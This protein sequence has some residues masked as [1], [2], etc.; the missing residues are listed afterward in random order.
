MERKRAVRGQKAP[1]MADVAR[2][3]KVSTAAVSYVVSGDLD[4]LKSVGEGA[5]ARILKAIDDLNY[6]QNHA[7]RQLRRRQAERICLLLPRLG[8]PFSDR[9]AQDVRTAAESRNFSTIIAAGHTEAQIERVMLE[10]E[11]GLADGMIADLQHLNDAQVDAMTQRLVAAGKPA[12]VFHPT[13]QPHAFSVV[14]QHIGEAIDLALEHLYAAGHRRIA[15]ML[16]DAAAEQSRFQAYRAFLQRKGLAADPDLIVRGAS[17][18]AGADAAATDLLARKDRPT[19][20]LAE[21]D[22][23]AVTALNTVQAAGLRVPD[24]MAIVGCGDVDEG[25]FS[26]P[27]LTTVGPTSTSFAALADHLIAMILDREATAPQ[28]FDVPWRLVRRQS[29]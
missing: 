11:S 21:S 14:R 22:I 8:V 6:V 20:L 28:L 27:P 18:R 23:G 29:A 25:R 5:R 19:A 9:I 12:I 4:R 15:Y 10:V 16:H 13:L 3:A 24:D 1:T 7:A 17:S 26:R 2:H